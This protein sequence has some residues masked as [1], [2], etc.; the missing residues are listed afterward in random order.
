[1][2]DKSIESAEFPEGRAVVRGCITERSFA[3][4]P[5]ETDPLSLL[6]IVRLTVDFRGMN[7]DSDN[8][9]MA[10]KM[11]KGYSSFRSYCHQKHLYQ[12]NNTQLFNFKKT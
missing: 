4:I 10:V 8:R 3:V 5:A 7:N 6:C 11:L 12:T 1:M 2:V 9:N